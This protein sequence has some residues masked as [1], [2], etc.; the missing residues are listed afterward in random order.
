MRLPL[1]SCSLN[2]ST[3]FRIAGNMA[4]DIQGPPKHCSLAWIDIMPGV[5]IGPSPAH[6]C[7]DYSNNIAV[8]DSADLRFWVC[9]QP[10]FVFFRDI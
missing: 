1:F 5:Q 8:D 4:S 7:W 9:R 3:A 10:Q 6:R 2:G